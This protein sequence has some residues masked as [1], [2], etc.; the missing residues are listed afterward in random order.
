MKT[1]ERHENLYYFG[2]QLLRDS[3]GRLFSW[4]GS[5]DWTGLLSN[6]C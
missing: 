2:E 4:A 5:D 6:R 3:N 1:A